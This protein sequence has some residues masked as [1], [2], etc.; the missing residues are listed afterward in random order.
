MMELAICPGGGEKKKKAVT[1][2]ERLS[3]FSEYSKWKS[4]ADSA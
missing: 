4:H 1:V 2:M 3:D